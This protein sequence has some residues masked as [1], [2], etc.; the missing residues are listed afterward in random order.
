MKKC[1]LYLRHLIGAVLNPL[2][3]IKEE[4]CLMYQDFVTFRQ[5]IGLIK[6]NYITHLVD[7]VPVVFMQD[8]DLDSN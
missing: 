1:V 4:L 3:D 6:E 8:M 2:N 7:G 5:L